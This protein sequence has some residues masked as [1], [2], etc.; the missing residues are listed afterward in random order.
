[1]ESPRD[2]GG[3]GVSPAGLPDTKGI[4]TKNVPHA[5]TKSSYKRQQAL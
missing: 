4:K 2:R 3:R 1:M 5:F